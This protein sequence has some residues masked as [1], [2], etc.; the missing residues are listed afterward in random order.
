MS[1]TAYHLN[2]GEFKCIILSDGCIVD[3]TPEGTQSFGVNCLYIEA[4]GRKMLVDDGCG[5]IFRSDTAGRLVKN[6]KLTGIEP[7][8]IDTIIFS[9]GHID[10]VCGTFSKTGEPVFTNARYIMTRKEWD[11]I[12]APPGDNEMQKMFY[13]PA[14]QFLLPL[15]ERF[16][17]VAG[18]YEVVPGIKTIPA[19]GH[20]P[21]NAMIAISSQGERLL[22]ICDVMHSPREFTEPRCLAMFDVMP[23]AAVKTRAKILA[24]LA[25]D[26]AFVFAGHFTFPGLGYIRRKNGVFSWDP[27]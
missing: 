8:D 14:R 22:C 5:Q 15:E 19:Y 11:F 17:L 13:R 25:K 26:D 2:I 10:H 6:L 3:K 20:T 4:G 18:N 7:E 21:G 24:R 27:I 12:K 16:T 23:E 1:E 9:H